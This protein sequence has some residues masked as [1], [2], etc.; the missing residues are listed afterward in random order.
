MNLSGGALEFIGNTTLGNS[1]FTLTAPT[2]LTVDPGVTAII[3]PSISGN[4]AAT[5]VK[6]G[7]GTLVYNGNN[8]YLGA[9]SVTQGTLQVNGT[10]SAAQQQ[11]WLVPARPSVAQG[12]QMP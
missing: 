10:L 8:T 1:S 5:V 7:T 11:H 2:T 3:T 9:T 4:A 6:N 12:L